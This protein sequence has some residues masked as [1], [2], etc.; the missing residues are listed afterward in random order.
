MGK[1]EVALTEKLIAPRTTQPESGV[2]YGLI[3]LSVGIA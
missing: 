2:A 3:S 1:V